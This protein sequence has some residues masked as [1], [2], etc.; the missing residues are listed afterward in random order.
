VQ[1]SVNGEERSIR[2]AVRKSG[3]FYTV[4]RGMNSGD[5]TPVTISYTYRT[6]TAERGHLLYVDIDLPTQRTGSYPRYIPNPARQPGKLHTR[7]PR[8]DTSRTSANAQPVL[9]GH[10]ARMASAARLTSTR[11]APVPC[12]ATIINHAVS[13]PMTPKGNSATGTPTQRRT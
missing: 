11:H 10:G 7:R 12:S 9:A 6:V 5:E 13:E 2:R 1:F 3:Q 4:S 8:T